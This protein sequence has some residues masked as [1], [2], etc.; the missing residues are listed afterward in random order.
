[1]DILDYFDRQYSTPN[2]SR[3]SGIYLVATNGL[4]CTR[5]VVPDNVQSILRSHSS[6][7][8]FTLEIEIMAQGMKTTKRRTLTKDQLK[9]FR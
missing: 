1:M 4:R 9:K 2:K 8:E 7:R 3:V 6:A 5:K